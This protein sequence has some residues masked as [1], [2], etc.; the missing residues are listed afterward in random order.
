VDP[1]LEE[2]MTAKKKISNL[3]K[4]SVSAKKA[5]V[6]KGGATQKPPKPGSN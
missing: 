3:P 2:A 4:K 6:I 5:S 1:F